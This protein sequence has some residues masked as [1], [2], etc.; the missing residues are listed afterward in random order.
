MDCAV[1]ARPAHP[2]TEFER[3]LRTR[4]DEAENLARRA[5]AEGDEDLAEAMRGHAAD[6]R[7]TAGLHELALGTLAAEPWLPATA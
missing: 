5:E 6:L 7:R 4:L 2:G 3:E 1:P